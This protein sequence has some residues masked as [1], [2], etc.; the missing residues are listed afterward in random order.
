MDVAAQLAAAAS[1]TVTGRLEIATSAAAA[2]I[3]LRDGRIS[4]VTGVQARPAL[5][6]RLVSGGW[7]SLT[8]LGNALAAQSQHPQMRLGDVLV[9]MGLVSRGDVEQVAFEQMCD[10]VALILTWSEPVIALTEMM[11]DAVPPGG[12]QVDELL[13]AARER[14][15]TWREM[16]RQIGGPDTVPQ[17]SD[18]VMSAK[19]AALQPTDWAVLCRVDG[20]RSLRSIAEQAGLTLMEAASILKG[21]LAAGLTAIPAAHLPPA[22]S[23]PPSWPAPASASIDLQPPQPTARPDAAVRRPADVPVT[24]AS[25]TTHRAPPPP[26]PVKTVWPVEQYDDPADLLRELSQLSGTDQNARRRGTH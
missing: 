14:V 9:R 8:S 10:D 25:K 21:L 23:R 13:S 11:P 17:L 6:M 18:D 16:V 15:H 3:L 7:L 24:G 4:A 20:H 2:T 26:P 19:D 12:P 5:G 22:Q 1:R